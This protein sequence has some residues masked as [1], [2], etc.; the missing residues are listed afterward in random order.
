MILSAYIPYVTTLRGVARTCG[1]DHHRVRRVLE[2][3]G[4]AVVRGKIG[5][6]SDDRRAKIG[7][8]SKGRTSWAKGK[9]MPKISLYKNMAAHLRFDVSVE[10]LLLFEDIEKLKFLNR[11][12]RRGDRFVLTS[13]E[14][15]AYIVRFYHD[16]Q[17]NSAYGG[18]LKSGKDKWKRPTIDHINPRANGGCNMLNNLQFLTWFENRAKCD[19][20]QKEWDVVKHNIKDYLI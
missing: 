15:K 11:C 1:T 19:M 4:I 20:T 13:E 12:V 5:P 7:E 3:N 9:K 8:A 14:Y 18:W 10:W 17:F 2:Q 16:D 6:F